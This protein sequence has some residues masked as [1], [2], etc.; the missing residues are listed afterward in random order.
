MYVRLEDTTWYVC[1]A[2]GMYV[3]LEDTTWYVCEARGY[4]MVCM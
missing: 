1:E 4:H 3:R 2:R